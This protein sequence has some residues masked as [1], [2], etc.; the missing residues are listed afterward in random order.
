M[1][2]PSTLSLILILSLPTVS[3]SGPFDSITD[4]LEDVGSTLEKGVKEVVET[5]KKIE[6]E[7][8]RTPGNL[9]EI[10]VKV[11]T[12]KDKDDLI[13]ETRAKFGQ[14]RSALVASKSKVLSQFTPAFESI[15]EAIGNAQYIGIDPSSVRQ[16]DGS[17]IDLIAQ[18][19]KLVQVRDE[20]LAQLDAE[21]N[22][23]NQQENSAIQQIRN[24]FS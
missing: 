7:L 22:K 1:K 21:I 13:N 17:F 4:A 5:P 23:I 18:K 19:A 24:Q 9:K 14:A 2:F 11:S 20:T 8:K 15:T 12:G 6:K 3:L 16:S 10:A